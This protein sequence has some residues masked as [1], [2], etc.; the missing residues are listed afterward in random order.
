[1]SSLLRSLLYPYLAPG[2]DGTEGG[3]AGGGEATVTDD[4]AAGGGDGGENLAPDA[5]AD[6]SAQAGQG[7]DA[8]VEGK[9]APQ[10]KKTAQPIEKGMLEAIKEGL[11]PDE[12]AEPGTK[13]SPAKAVDKS[14]M[15]ATE[16]AAADA[17]EKK[18]LEAKALADLK[19]RAE[20]GDA[21][22][23]AELEKRD[24]A[25]LKGKKADDFVLTPEEKKVLGPK[26]QARF[27]E[28]HKYAKT[29]E[30]EVLQLQGKYATLETARDE[31]MQA[32]Q[33]YKVTP[34]DIKALFGY[35]KVV[36]E[37]RLEEAL[38][39]IEAT[40]AALL[41]SLGREAPGVDLL[42]DFPDLAKKV[43]DQEMTREAGLEVARARRDKAA[44]EA[45][46]AQR[47]QQDRGT[48]QIQQR[49][50][51]GEA[52]IAAWATK[53]AKEDIDYAAKEEKVLARVAGVVRR[54]PPELWL[55][56]LQEIYDSIEV[57]KQAGERGHQPLRPSGA[58]GGPKQPADMKDAIAQGLGYPAAG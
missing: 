32:F 38:K 42:K 31:L 16:R 18:A 21:A 11:A 30:G 25:K 28:L 3:G 50:Q 40:R 27:H 39:M 35:N 13:K 34:E 54:Y 7:A 22:A 15:T 44:R 37:G 33:A 26:A 10:Q 46:D 52:D 57:V 4:A 9:E 36:K 12:G 1:M 19:K 58:K 29:K 53:M 43:E 47:Q 6:A 51:K 23:K 49:R 41:R 5:G 14:Q 20:A 2:G 45:A 8:G 48:Q 24:G 55:P 17:A 56:T